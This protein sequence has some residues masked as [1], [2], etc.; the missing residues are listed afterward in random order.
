MGVAYCDTE[1]LLQA[2]YSEFPQLRCG[3]PDEPVMIQLVRHRNCAASRALP[4]E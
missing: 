3:N 1:E 2:A 4:D